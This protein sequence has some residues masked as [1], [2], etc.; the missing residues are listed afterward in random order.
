MGKRIDLTGVRV[1]RLVVESYAYT[2]DKKA[3]WNCVCDCGNKCVVGAKNLR[4]GIARSCGC[5]KKESMRKVASKHGLSSTRLY[6]IW[7]GM[8]GRCYNPNNPRYNSYGGRGIL[9]HEEWLNNF[10]SFYNWAI[11]N[12]YAENL[13]LDRIDNNR[14]YSPDNCRWAN[15]KQ[16]CNN[17][18]NNHLLTYNGKTQ[19]I[20]QW[21]EELGI[22]RRTLTDRLTYSW[23]LEEV[24]TKPLKKVNQELIEY[25]GEQ[26]T[27]SEWAK[28][29]DMPRSILYKR[30]KSGMSLEEAFTKP[31]G[32]GLVELNGKPG[33][34]AK[35][36]KE[37]GISEATVRG[38]LKKGMT[39]EEALTTPVDNRYTRKVNRNK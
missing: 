11:S 19:N 12:G 32:R 26:H 30:L 18:S 22:G 3:Y 14:G 25:N 24:F 13:T 5:L 36:A 2:R 10:E 6:H 31:V 33:T 28:I 37:Y 4:K 23:T 1:G 7:T 20:T 35:F 9:I 34:V 27:L 21:A 17:K 8:K 16:Q 15:Q 38:R 39:L 29:I